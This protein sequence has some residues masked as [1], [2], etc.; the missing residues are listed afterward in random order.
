MAIGGPGNH[1][2]I[3]TANYVARGYGVKAA[4]PVSTAKKLCRELIVLPPDFE[5]YHELSFEMM[6][7]VA[8]W[9]EVVEPMSADEAYLGFDSSVTFENALERAEEI[10]ECV[11]TSTG[12]DVTVGVSV[13]RALA[14]MVCS[15]AK[16]NGAKVVG[17]DR[18][19]E[20]LDGQ[21]LSKI[22]G[23]GPASLRKLERI[24]CRSIADLRGISRERLISVLG[25][26][27]AEYLSHVIVGED[28][29]S[30]SPRSTQLSIST[31]ETLERTVSSWKAYH[32]N[33]TRVA[34][35]TVARMWDRGVGAK[36][37]SL[38]VRGEGSN[39][40]SRTTSLGQVT[41][42]PEIIFAALTR[43]EKRV[44]EE[45]GRAARQ[46]SV[47]VGGLGAGIQLNLDLAGTGYEPPAPNP[48][49]EVLSVVEHRTFGRGEI[50]TISP[51][52]A[53]VRFV[54]GKVRVISDPRTH[55]ERV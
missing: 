17:E 19:E 52:S 1:S 38:T 8:R 30:V 53:V 26:A 51:D 25:V 40:A 3:A 7:S 9:C 29:A 14:K 39:G 20:F 6:A 16:P 22:P 55:L 35:T 13:S 48:L 11:K 31:S 18:V 36:S 27:G 50:V 28:S 46:I 4:M 5:L 32:E 43:L 12:L 21:A 34:R 37:L 33:V 45:A 54:D 2:V 23:L 15:S 42:N 47:G 10:R 44:Y 49:F 41:N 24:N